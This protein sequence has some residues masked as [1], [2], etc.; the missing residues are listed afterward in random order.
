MEKNECILCFFAIAA[1]GWFVL[2][3]QSFHAVKCEEKQ[4]KHLGPY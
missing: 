1:D 2:K 4:N 3:P